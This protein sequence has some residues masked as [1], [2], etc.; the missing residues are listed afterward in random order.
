VLKNTTLQIQLAYSF[1][2]KSQTKLKSSAEYYL[3]I[4]WQITLNTLRRWYIKNTKQF[5]WH[6]LE[7]H[8][9]WPKKIY[10]WNIDVQNFIHD[11]S[12]R[13]NVLNLKYIYVLHRP[14][15]LVSLP[16]R[17]AKDF[18][19]TF[20]HVHHLLLKKKEMKILET[21]NLCDRKL[22]FDACWISIRR[23]NRKTSRRD[24]SLK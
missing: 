17:K 6:D 2:N 21:W 15:N 16:W 23:S 22:F 5:A 24:K 9:L 12:S 4:I 10:C 11:P 20:Q 1:Y 14:M 8:F 13:S 19:Q 3:K 7:K 18:C